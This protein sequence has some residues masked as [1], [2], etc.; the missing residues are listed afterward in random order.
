MAAPFTTTQEMRNII[1]TYEGFSATPYSDFKQFSIGF[2]S[3]I[4][5][6]GNP[7]T[8]GTPPI[9]RRQAESLFNEVT[10]PIYE[11]GVSNVVVRNDLPIDALSAL[12][13]FAYNLGVGALGSSTLLKRIEASRWGDVG[14]QWSKWT[15]VTPPDPDIS[16]SLCQ[17]R[18]HEFTI[19]RNALINAGVATA[20]QFNFNLT[21]K[22]PMLPGPSVPD[23]DGYIASN[24]LVDQGEISDVYARDSRANFCTSAA[25]RSHSNVDKTRWSL[26]TTTDDQGNTTTSPGS[27]FPDLPSGSLSP[28]TP[29]NTVEAGVQSVPIVV[30][31]QDE[32]KDQFPEIAAGV[33]VSTAITPA[34]N[35]PVQPAKFPAV[36]GPAATPERVAAY[37]S[38][39]IENQPANVVGDVRPGYPVSAIP[40]NDSGNPTVLVGGQPLAHLLATTNDGSGG[41][42]IVGPGGAP[43]VIMGI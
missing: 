9:N 3:G 16:N 27:L 33:P 1:M 4:D 30:L 15:K 20:G 25:R 19:F 8:A 34:G 31:G 29:D 38:V 17:R 5:L 13:S 2:G 28:A 32:R 10:L 14:H 12:V 35:N 23:K 40:V 21:L 24:Q 42:G 11:K 39:L 18:H 37:T 41:P 26:N 36:P 22:D 6:D 43:T 7:V